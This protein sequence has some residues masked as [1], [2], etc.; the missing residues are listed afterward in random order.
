MIMLLHSFITHLT[1]PHEP[2]LN[3]HTVLAIEDAEMNEKLYLISKSSWARG[4]IRDISRYVYYG[5][6]CTTDS[7][8]DNFFLAQQKRGI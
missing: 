8:K 7:G 3:P 4:R 1:S 5:V 6:M 2:S